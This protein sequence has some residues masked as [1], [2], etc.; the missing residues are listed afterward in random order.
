MEQPG[1]G[2]QPTNLNFQVPPD[3]EGGAY[4]NILGVWHTGHEFTLDFAVTQPAIAPTPAEPTTV[5]CRVVARVK[6]PPSVIFEMLRAINQ[7]MTIYDNQFGE[8][9]RPGS[10][11]EDQPQ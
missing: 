2:R 6:I 4:A 1:A 3:L 5:P 9:Q 11:Q 8:I 7:N 10:T